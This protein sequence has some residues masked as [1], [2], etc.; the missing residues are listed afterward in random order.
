M[1][2]WFDRTAFAIPASNIGRFGYAGVGTLVGPPTR[3]FSA[4]VAKTVA[5]WER[6]SL[7]I[8]ATVNNLTNTANFDLPAVNVSNSNF[9]RIT[10]TVGVDNGGSRTLQVGA[11]IRF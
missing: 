6:V 10:S 3:S 1:D 4:R 7:G 2:S 9:D 11:R 5:I 8:E